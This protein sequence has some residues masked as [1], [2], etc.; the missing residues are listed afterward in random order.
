MEQREGVNN[1]TLKMEQQGLKMV[2]DKEQFA[3]AL[4]TWRIRQGLTQQQLA[5]KW[6]VS[7][8]SIL[9]AEGAKEIGWIAIYRMFNQM[10]AE[11][12]EEIKQ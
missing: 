2:T 9:R 12:R 3:V 1:I 5:D 4:K 10:A 11:M 7:R 8:Y 6:G